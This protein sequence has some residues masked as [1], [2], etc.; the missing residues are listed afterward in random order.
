M[1]LSCGVL[2]D[3][4]DVFSPPTLGNHP[5]VLTA[6]RLDFAFVSGFCVQGL[7]IWISFLLAGLFLDRPSSRVDDTDL[8]RFTPQLMLKQHTSKNIRIGSATVPGVSMDKGIERETT[9]HQKYYQILCPTPY[10]DK[11][12]V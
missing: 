4:D 10:Q 6:K 1:W 12:H 3:L 9:T 5:G 2:D 7:G 8:L 11:V